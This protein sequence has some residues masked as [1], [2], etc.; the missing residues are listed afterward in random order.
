MNVANHKRPHVYNFMYRKYP[1][2]ANL[3]RQKIDSCLPRAG[4]VGE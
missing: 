3:W 1:E 2:Q 4:D